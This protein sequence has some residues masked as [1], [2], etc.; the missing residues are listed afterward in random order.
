MPPPRVPRR[1][2][3]VAAGIV[4]L[5]AGVVVALRNQTK[6][7]G[8]PGDG[9][10][11]V[12][13]AVVPPP[14]PPDT[15]AA[16][17]RRRVA[18]AKSSDIHWSTQW[19][20]F[21]RGRASMPLTPAVRTV[22]DSAR[23]PARIGQ[24]TGIVKRIDGEPV[25]GATVV[26]VPERAAGTSI[27]PSPEAARRTTATTSDGRFSLLA[28]EGTRYA[29]S[30]EIA[31]YPPAVAHNATVGIEVELL[32]VRYVSALIRVKDG[33]GHAVA[34]ARVEAVPVERRGGV[35]HR[36]DSSD[37]GGLAELRGLVDGARYRLVIV[38]PPGPPE[39]A[40]KR[41]EDWSVAETVVEL[42]AP[43]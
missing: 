31:E 30:T 35:M 15:L 14:L 21:D 3:V 17:T 38:A 29:L 39:L 5:L 2:L 23:P 9:S 41:I 22:E 18:E 16:P 6:R 43:R 12:G 11:A 37:G 4:A 34:H 27:G 28:D 26:A 13:A 25:G 32:V 7:V 42:R 8:T 33:N 10:I 20:T 19:D 40:D 24:L 1:P 36:M